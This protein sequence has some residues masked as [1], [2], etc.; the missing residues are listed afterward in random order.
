[1]V[2]IFTSVLVRVSCFDMDP[3]LRKAD[4]PLNIKCTEEAKKKKIE[5]YLLIAVAL[6]ELSR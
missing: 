2:L 6:F 5:T 4:N 3:V 1:M